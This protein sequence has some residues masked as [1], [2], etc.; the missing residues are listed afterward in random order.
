MNEQFLIFIMKI[1]IFFT[2]FINLYCC[3]SQQQFNYNFYIDDTVRE[4]ALFYDAKEDTAIYLDKLTSR[5]KVSENEE[6]AD[7]PFSFN[8]ETDLYFFKNNSEVLFT[9]N[10]FRTNYLVEDE[11]PKMEW[12]LSAEKRE[13]NNLTC[14][15]ATTKFRGRNWTAWYSPDVPI[16][17]GPWKFYGLPGIIVEIKDDSNRFAFALVEYILNS[18]NVAPTID[19]SNAKKVTMKEMAEITDEAYENLLNDLIN[20]GPRDEVLVE[21]D[22]G[23]GE[24]IESIY[25]WE[26]EK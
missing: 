23:K 11:L 6:T 24:G 1:L 21:S 5:K 25:E 10:L 8:E 3:Y 22:T 13:I 18:K 17:Y 12:Q 4:G 20:S 14:Y 15:K 19:F 2:F 9:Y 16:N 26:E 7:I